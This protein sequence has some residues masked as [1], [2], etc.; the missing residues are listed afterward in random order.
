ML[1][2]RQDRELREITLEAFI[3]HMVK[4]T[5]PVKWLAHQRD[6]NLKRELQ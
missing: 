4:A 6:S 2:K 1:W 3:T 5:S